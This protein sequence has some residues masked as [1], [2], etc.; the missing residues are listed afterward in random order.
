LY[1]ESL[2]LV[3]LKYEKNTDESPVCSFQWDQIKLS[4]LRI[5]KTN[6]LHRKI[7]VVVVLF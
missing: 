2:F 5:E 6:I 1:T 4:L 3:F 7:V